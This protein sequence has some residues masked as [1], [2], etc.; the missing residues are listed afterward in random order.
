MLMPLRWP[1]HKTAI[2]SRSTRLSG[3]G[4]RPTF[5]SPAESALPGCPGEGL[6]QFGSAL[7][8]HYA[9]GSHP[10]SDVSTWSLV[11]TEPCCYRALD[12]VVASGAS[13]GQ[14]LTV[15]PDDTIDYL[16]Q[17]APH[18]PQAFRFAFLHC[19]YIFLFLL[20]FYFST[21][22]LLFLVASRLSEC[23]WL[24]QDL[25]SGVI[26]PAYALWLWAGV[27]SGVV[28]TPKP[29]RSPVVV[30]SAYSLSRL[31]GTQM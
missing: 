27:I 25:V 23:L 7:R 24:S 18:Y 11:V 8:N 29:S 21:I 13:T 15:V 31:H 19:A 10:R 14:D 17:A 6:G 28:C 26:C 4:A 9:P 2:Q 12:Q 20:L 30:I 22:F 3:Q 5:L 1:P 16:Y